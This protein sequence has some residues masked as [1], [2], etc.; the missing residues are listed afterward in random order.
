MLDADLAQL[1]GVTTKALNLAVKRNKRRFPDDFVFQLN[2]DE[3]QQVVTN[4]DHHARLRFS[5]NL[6]FAKLSKHFLPAS[7]DCRRQIL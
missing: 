6:P 1:F 7:V 4:C 3:K 5:S 2:A